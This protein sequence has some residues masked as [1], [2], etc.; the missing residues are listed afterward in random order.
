[1]RAIKKLFVGAIVTLTLPLAASAQLVLSAPTTGV[2]TDPVSITLKPGFSTTSFHAYITSILPPM[3]LGSTPSANQNYIRT[4]TYLSATVSATPQTS[5][6]M[7]DISYYDGLGRPVLTIGTKGSPSYKDII[8]AQSY[9]AFGREDRSYLPYA[10]AATGN[11]AYRSAAVTEQAT[12]YNTPPTGVVTIAKLASGATPSFS[13]PVYEASPLNR[14]LEEGFAGAVWQPG[15]RGTNTGRTMV[16]EYTTNNTTGITDLANTRLAKLYTVTYAAGV[17]KLS[18]TGNYGANQLYVTVRKDENWAGGSGT[19]ASRLNTTEEYTDKQGRLVLKRTFNAKTVGTTVT[20]EILST[21]YVYDD[22]GNLCFVLT[23]ISNA[24][25]A[26]PAQAVL[27]AHCYQYRYD[28]RN[29]MT[30]K[31]VPAKGMEYFNY[32]PLDQL[33]F[34]M[35]ARDSTEAYSVF[36]NESGKKYHRFYKYDGLGRMIITGWEKG[37]V[38]TQAEIDRWI[39]AHPTHWEQRSSATGNLHGY[40]NNAMPQDASLFDI[41]EVNYYDRYDGIGLPDNLNKT[42]A[43]GVSAKIQGLLVAKKTKVIGSNNVYLWTVYYYDERGDNIRTLSQH[44]K[45]GAYNLN[46][47]DDI[48]NEYTFTHKLKKST[49]NHYAGAATAALT[50]TTEYTYDHRDR[51]LDTWKTVTGGAKT[52]VARN[53]YNEVG[54]LRAKQL[55]SED[56]GGTFGQRI[57]YAYNERGWLRYANSE[58]MQLQLQYN[59]GTAKYYNGNI[60]YQT[61]SRKHTDGTTAA[62]TYSYTYDAISRLR[63]GI[64][65]GGK[66]REEIAYDKLGNITALNRRASDGLTADSLAYSYSGGRL[67]SVNDRSTNTGAAYMLAGTTAYTY[68]ANGNMKT[69]VNSANTANNITATVYNYLDLPQTVTA[70]GTTVSFIYD[71]SGRKLRSINGI[72]G[73][74]RDYIDGIEYSGTAL[75]LI[76]MEEGR[77]LKGTGGYSYEYILKDH[78]GNSRSGF[79]GTDAVATTANFGSDYYPFGLQYQLKIGQPSPKNNYLYNGQEFQDKLKAY[80]FGFRFYDPVIGRWAGVDPLAENHHEFTPYNY[81]LGNPITYGDFMGLDTIRRD[82]NRTTPKAGDDIQ[83]DDGSLNSTPIDAAVVTASAGPLA[84]SITGPDIGPVSGFWN[85]AGVYT[86]GRSQNGFSYDVNGRSLG[87]TP[88]MGLPPDFGIGKPTALINLLKRIRG[89][90]AAKGGGQLLLTAGKLHR[91]HVL[92]QQ[93]RK[94]FAQ[95]GISNIDDYAIQISQSTHLKGVHGKGLGAQLPGE[96]NKQWIDF[97]KANPNASPSEIFHHAEGLLKRYGLEHLQYVPYK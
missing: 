27:D 39:S 83:G 10:T 47:Y 75:E 94:W 33:V 91:H 13:R 21:Y 66:G 26:L 88:L 28:R 46:N 11:G 3:A 76:H 57:G 42:T 52:L 8:S 41:L 90:F 64:M 86:F 56:Q 36:P 58:L 89:L 67:A 49:R 82:D 77:I 38:G 97:I 19:F 23:P 1:M 62:G 61:F 53:E 35:T 16:T 92:P 14:V 59:T 45:G 5:E 60:A 25:A 69:R 63:E 51:L 22:F 73:Q 30:H 40:T 72:N 12:F 84:I 4:R 70:N 85:R 54:Q 17:P 74:T 15:T 71:G 81:V 79:K 7:E 18:L 44:Y 29:R 32:N 9:D 34:H 68:D 48:I 2:K 6:I 65:A 55:H 24:D 95:R 50:V 37:R 96:W 31:K 78:L 93:F 80:D 87:R 43:A 20:N